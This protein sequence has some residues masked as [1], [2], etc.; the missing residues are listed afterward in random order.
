MQKHLPYSVCSFVFVCV[1]RKICVCGL[2]IYAII[3]FFGGLYAVPCVSA[4]KLKFENMYICRTREQFK[5][6][7][8]VLKMTPVNYRLVVSRPMPPQSCHWDCVLWHNFCGMK[9]KYWTTGSWRCCL[10][11]EVLS[12]IPA[13]SKI[14]YPFLCGFICVFLC[15][16]LNPEIYI[17]ICISYEHGYVVSPPTVF[18]QRF[19]FTEEDNLSVFDSNYFLVPEHQH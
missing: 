2:W 13:R 16:R 5:I 17:Y 11:L 14:I 18:V 19:F 7:T 10:S 1:G 9:L 8:H 15:H 6:N 12:S 3:G 4:S